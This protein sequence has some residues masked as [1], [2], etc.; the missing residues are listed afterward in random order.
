VST[1]TASSTRAQVQAAYDDNA[2]YAEDADA[3][4]ARG[5]LTAARILLR[6]LA[7]EIANGID[8]VRL[9]E[10]LRQIRAEITDCQRW[11]AANGGVDNGGA[12]T[13]TARFD[14]MTRY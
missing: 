5:F 3:A 12:G 14:E 11:L 2:S 1:L 7:G 8:R 13:H 6:R 10:N 4:K 9:D